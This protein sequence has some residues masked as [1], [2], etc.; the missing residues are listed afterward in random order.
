MDIELGATYA[1]RINDGGRFMARADHFLGDGYA[2]ILIPTRDAVRDVF[3]HGYQLG[4]AH[5]DADLERVD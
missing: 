5:W 1:V 4:R 3:P 2:V